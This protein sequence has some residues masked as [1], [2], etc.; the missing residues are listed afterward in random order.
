MISSLLYS[1]SESTSQSQYPGFHLNRS[2]KSNLAVMELSLPIFIRSLSSASPLLCITNSVLLFSPYSAQFV[3]EF[4]AFPF[5]SNTS[6]SSYYCF[7]YTSLV[8]PNHASQSPTEPTPAA[9][10]PII[11]RDEQ[12]AST[13]LS[14]KSQWTPLPLP[15]ASAEWISSSTGLSLQAGF[16]S[17]PDSIPLG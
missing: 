4:S 6:I 14:L 7:Y 9:P 17:E 5:I 11:T 12:P 1:V 10:P 16:L 8:N 15:L 13:N 3:S 2:I